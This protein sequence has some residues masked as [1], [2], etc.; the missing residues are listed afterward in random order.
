MT[1]C[2]GLPEKA[3]CIFARDD[4]GSFLKAV[5]SFISVLLVCHLIVDSS[6][7]ILNKNLTIWLSFG[8]FTSWRWKTKLWIFAMFYCFTSVK[9]K[10]MSSL[11]KLLKVYGDNAVQE[12]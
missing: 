7:F 1:V 11:G 4:T 3:W 9:E 2:M 8:D 10:H 12:Q 6:S 5:K